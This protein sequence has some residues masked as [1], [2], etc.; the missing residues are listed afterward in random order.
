MSDPR[1]TAFTL[2]EMMIAI[3]LGLVLIYTAT[4]GFRVASQSITIANRL[5]L[6]NQLM[7]T[8]IS[9]AH[10]QL[11]FWTNLDDPNDSNRQSLRGSADVSGESWAYPLVNGQ[12]GGGTVGL[13]FTPF[14]QSFPAG[15]RIPRA[16]GGAS[17]ISGA[18]VV[19]QGTIAASDPTWEQDIGF[20]PSYAWAAHDPRTW[21]R[22]NVCEKLRG[23]PPPIDG[24]IP[25]LWFGRYGIFSNTETNP[26]YMTFANIVADPLTAPS[27]Y[28]AD[29]AAS[30]GEFPL[31]LWYG[32]QLRGL[33]HTLGFY[34]TCDYLPSNM[35]YGCYGT[36][37]DGSATNQD[38]MASLFL[39]TDGTF[40]GTGMGPTTLGLYG[41]SHANSFGV[42][43]PYG[44]TVNNLSLAREDYRHYATDYNVINQTTATSELGFFI[45]VTL[46]L[47]KVL[48]PAPAQWPV[49]SVAV[50]HFLKSAHFVNMAKVRW[51]SP[52]T[53]QLAE[54]S[55]TSVGTTLRGA[56][57]QRRHPDSGGGWA[58]WDNRSGA[59]NDRT[60]DSP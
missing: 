10:E 45:G 55:F 3:S 54:L 29:Y 14:S 5:S 38:G 49:V 59:S 52:L 46:P 27:P 42:T 21:F 56:R 19:L 4:S 23:I 33:S 34:G 31:H 2:I 36:Y 9:L 13:P 32:R 28:S 24:S 25:P 17:A 37:T 35:M 57:M 26:N 43:N 41:F 7:R 50:G 51:V 40:I 30:S 1:R 60:L 44:R 18:P 48:D 53:G 39:Q 22:G 15:P 20:D 11:D 12:S 58:R 47:T 8:G 6:E 16:A